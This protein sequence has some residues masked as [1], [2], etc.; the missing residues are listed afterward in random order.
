LLPLPVSHASG[1][2]R[3]RHESAGPPPALALGGAMSSLRHSGSRLGML[4]V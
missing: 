2:L 3:H 4:V 1:V